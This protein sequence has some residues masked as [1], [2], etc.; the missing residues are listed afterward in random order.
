MREEDSFMYNDNDDEAIV[1][2]VLSGNREAYG[3]IVH[4]YKNVVFNVI[5]A[6]IRNYHTAEDLTQDT[7]VDGYIHLKSLKEPCKIGAWLIKIA[8]NKCYNYMTRSA[9]RYES[10]LHEYIPDERMAT[11]ETFFIEQYDHELLKQAIHHLPELH[12]TVTELYYFNDFSQNKIAEF[13]KIPVGTVSRRLYD[14]R[15]KLKKELNNM[16][17]TIKNV[18]FEAE[19]AKRI[20]TL[21]KYYHLNN[22]SIDGK[23]KI[24]DEF[25]KFIN[26]IPESKLKHR[27]YASAYNNSDKKEYKSKIEKETELGENADVYY[28][29]FFDKYANKNNN[30][31]WLKA[32]DSE[33]GIAK[34][35][36]MENSDN[37][38]GAMLFWRGACNMRLKRFGEAK[39]DF[40][41]SI[42]KLNPDNSYQPN[43]VA[44]IKTI[45]LLMSEP[46][47]YITG[48]NV[49]GECYRL[50]DDGKKLDFVNQ[51][52]FGN[53]Y[54]VYGINKF[55]GIYYYASN[56][57]INHNCWFFDLNN[58][59]FLGEDVCVTKNET[60]SVL[61]GTFEDCLHI[62]LN[63]KEDWAATAV[64]EIWYA[65]DVG[66]I[67]FRVKVDGYAEE[68][69]ELCEYDIKGG[70]GYMPA[71]IGNTWRYKNINLSELYQQIN[72][73]EITS[74][75]DE[76]E[77]GSKYI[78][79][80]VMQ[81]LRSSKDNC[82]SDTHIVLAQNALP[83]EKP[84]EWKFDTAI[85]NLK[86][87]NQKNTS[88]R[89][90]IYA[91]NALDFIE[92]C[93]D[94]YKN[95][96]VFLPSGVHGGV[97]SKNKETD[98]IIYNENIIYYMGPYVIWG[99]WYGARRC[100][101]LKPF[102]FL[103]ELAGTLYSDKWVI[104]YSE[105][106]KNKDGEV[107]LIVEDG[108]TVTTKSGIFENCVK[109]TFNLEWEGGKDD[110]LYYLHN[111]RYSHCGTKIYWYAPNVGIVK[112]DCI[113][114]EALSSSIE[115][116]EYKS[117]ATNGEY[118]PI[119]VGNR[120]IYDEVTLPANFIARKK[121]DLVSGIAD[122]FFMI[123]EQEMVFKGTEQ[124]YEEFK[125]TREK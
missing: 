56:G 20:K 37:A 85:T 98:S 72:E 74:V 95:N 82:D 92:R 1:T 13:L 19:V 63:T 103:R 90:S 25:I 39:T 48:Y 101:G 60:V 69:Y 22:F 12:K 59:K 11:P 66:L 116:T 88:V 27:A 78:Y 16:N 122:E 117:C 24:V 33:D 107:F 123:E 80:A 34:L 104:G 38:V 118:M 35:E 99:S 79:M 36:K 43:A 2:L 65:K 94:Y 67:K 9:L 113:W 21:E 89:S 70:K 53:S 42:K 29:L 125:K 111:L 61:A 4:R 112:H 31:N 114:G 30:E 81:I 55:D 49:T 46:D 109:V 54:P 3:D 6:V 91:H 32:I 45:D 97:I 121:Y 23:E 41:K 28:D 57:G 120:W 50:Y 105:K 51:P 93:A 47:K 68:I 52:G 18:D 73:Y 64:Y 76:P 119:Y 83:N 102:R 15:L 58:G 115:L 86:L 84:E 62:F 10:E 44:C 7:F 106:I 75:L 71:K 26:T 77:N 5:Y 100:I 14:A 87:A 8:K 124:E 108:G 17:E 110:G 96:W 40:E